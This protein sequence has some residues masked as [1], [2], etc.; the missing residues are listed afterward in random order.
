M[1]MVLRFLHLSVTFY[2]MAVDELT[3]KHHER[4]VEVVSPPGFEI[5]EAR[6]KFL[7][8]IEHCLSCLDKSV[9]L[10]A[11]ESMCSGADKCGTRKQDIL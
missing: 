11:T 10:S 4:Q 3:V 6:V 7:L 8:N 5:F 2:I 9:F 1:I